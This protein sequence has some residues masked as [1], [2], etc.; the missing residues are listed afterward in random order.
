M[1]AVVPHEAVILDVSSWQDGEGRVV[2]VNQD[3][4]PMHPI[5]EH[6]AVSCS[7]YVLRLYK[8]LCFSP[9]CC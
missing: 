3:R 2:Q 4:R 7:I 9:I 5:R 1:Q 8:T 6:A